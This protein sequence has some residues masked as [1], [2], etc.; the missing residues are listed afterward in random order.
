MIIEGIILAAGMSKRAKTNKLILDIMGKTMIERTIL[1]MYDKCSKIIVV[2]GHRIE[3]IWISTKSYSKVELVY[4]E[5]YLD[6]MYSS[7]KVGLKRTKGDRMF[8][9]PGDYP[10]IKSSTYTAI[11]K[12]NNDIIIPKYNNKN[13]HP[14]L[15]NKN[16]KNEIIQNSNHNSLRDFIKN[17]KVKYIDIHDPWILVDIDTMEDYDK[18]MA[19]KEKLILAK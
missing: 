3:D 7:V 14:L 17:K 4:N 13:G 19:N 8:I 9:V 1:S 16:L 10:F 6:G 2:G 11:S 18:I 15:I 12:Y 5:N